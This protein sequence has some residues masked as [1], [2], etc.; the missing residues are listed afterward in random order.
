MFISRNREPLLAVVTKLA[1]AIAGE[2]AV[3]LRLIRAFMLWMPDGRVYI[4]EGTP[5]FVSKAKEHWEA[6][7][8]RDQVHRYSIPQIQ[9][10]A[11]VMWMYPQDF[12]QVRSFLEEA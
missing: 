5:A 3:D 1:E 8:T 6:G 7:L 11:H 4:G 9:P 2:S 12:E 10:I